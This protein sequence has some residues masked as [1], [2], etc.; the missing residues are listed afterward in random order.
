[1]ACMQGHLLAQGPNEKFQRSL[2]LGAPLRIFI[3]LIGLFYWLVAAQRPVAI[4]YP[5][6]DEY[7]FI[8][9]ATSILHGDW[10]GP[11][12]TNTLVKGPMYPLFLALNSVT[13]LSIGLGQAILYF[14]ACLYFSLVVGKIARTKVVF[15]AIISTLLLLPI[16]F[17]ASTQHIL[18]DDFYTALTLFFF[19]SL[20]DLLFLHTRLSRALA[21]GALAGVLWLTRE[22]GVWIIPAAAFAVGVVL[23]KMWGPSYFLRARLTIWRIVVAAGTA[24]VIIATVAVI[25]LHYYGRAITNE[26]KDS[27]FQA[28]MV[29]LHRASY[30]DMKPFL[31]VPKQARL[32]I[33]QISPTFARLRSFLDPDNAPSPWNYACSAGPDYRTAC[34]DI[35]AGWFL[36]AFRDGAARVGAHKNA[37][38]AAEFYRSIADEVNAACSQG[39]LRCGPWLPSLLPYMTRNQIETIPRRLYLALRLAIMDTQ[40]DTEPQKSSMHDREQQVLQL[41]NHPPH[42]SGAPMNFT[43]LGWYK[44][45]G[46]DWISVKSPNSHITIS[47]DASPDVAKHFSDARLS[48]QRF[49]ISGSCDDP[50]AM[51]VQDKEG[52]S[53]VIHPL[54][55]TSPQGYNIGKGTFYLDIVRILRDSNGYRGSVYRV[56]RRVVTIAHPFLTRLTETGIIAWF[57]LLIISIVRHEVT[58]NFLIV[59]TLGIAV[60]SRAAIL[61]IIDASSFPAVS[62]HYVLPAVPIALAAAIL[63]FREA[64][65]VVVPKFKLRAD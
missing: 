17:E 15:V 24:F 11:Y 53:L 39:R 4:W 9:Q 27:A 37:T 51:T 65:I 1:M 28:A 58:S 55:M 56:G 10:L 14:I 23:L 8:D 13:G 18:R 5:A 32:T 42:L 33:Y 22:E 61:A 57:A 35:A 20:F 60:I 25:N 19:G 44:G 62:F 59:C 46:D 30:F 26:L 6:G 47:R 63:A 2:A 54:A 21:V 41:L 40:F 38:I 16:G 12:W 29:A 64:L 43:L 7:L 48:R 49:T 45:E 36:W 31:P 52:E 3:A 34:G 50:C